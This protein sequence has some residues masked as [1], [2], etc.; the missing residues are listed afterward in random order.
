MSLEPMMTASHVIQLHAGAAMGA[1]L[2]GVCQFMLPK[3]TA[4]HRAAG[5]VWVA[6]M[7]LVCIS[8]FFIHEIRMLGP[9]SG[10]HLLSAFTLIVAP[11]AVMHARRGDIAA[12]RKAMNSLFWLALVGAGLFTLLPDRVVGQMVF[13]E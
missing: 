5:Y 13:G 10:I 1:L 11:L 7:M 12:H 2:L 8:S 4:L 3:G 9:F 6:A